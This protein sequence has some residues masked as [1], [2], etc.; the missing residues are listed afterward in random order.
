MGELEIATLPTVAR[1]DFFFT[2]IASH[3]YNE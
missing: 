2:V 3:E 1:N